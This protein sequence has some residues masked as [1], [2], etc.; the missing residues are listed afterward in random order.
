MKRHR[1]GRNILHRAPIWYRYSVLYRETPGGR[2]KQ[3]I[4]ESTT[5]ENARI[6]VQVMYPY[7][8]DV[9]ASAPIGRAP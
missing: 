8:I 1:V 9:A 7:A 6:A 4:I 2:V 5:R 3:E